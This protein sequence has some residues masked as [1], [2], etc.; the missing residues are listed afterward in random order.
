MKNIQFTQTPMATLCGGCGMDLLV[1]GLSTSKLSCHQ[2][3]HWYIHSIS[4]PQELMEMISQCLRKLMLHALMNFLLGQWVVQV[5]NLLRCLSWYCSQA[6]G[7]FEF[8]I[9]LMILPFWNLYIYSVTNG[10][11]GNLPYCINYREIVFKLLI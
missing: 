9:W 8:K 7:C 11:S 10:T 5:S 4:E 1:I 2:W 3:Y 6:A